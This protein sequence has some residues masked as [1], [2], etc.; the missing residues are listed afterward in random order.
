[1]RLFFTSLVLLTLVLGACTKENPELFDPSNAPEIVVNGKLSEPHE[2]VLVLPNGEMR[3]NP[4]DGRASYSH[5][6]IK[7]QEVC[8]FTAISK[9]EYESHLAILVYP[10]FSCYLMGPIL[11]LSD[12]IGAA[13]PLDWFSF[14]AMYG[15]ADGPET[16]TES[17]ISGDIYLRSVDGNKATLTFDYVTFKT[18]AGDHV[19]FGDQTYYLNEKD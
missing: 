4:F 16:G 17:K 12:Y 11:M 13:L 5:E 2:L 3:H 9:W 19:I 15:R 8:M 7:F 1:M 6:T 14:S 18:A 10:V